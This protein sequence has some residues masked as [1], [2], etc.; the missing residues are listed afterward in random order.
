MNTNFELKLIKLSNKAYRKVL[1]IC[2][3]RITK[4]LVSV[5]EEL[6]KQMDFAEQLETAARQTL[7]AADLGRLAAVDKHDEESEALIELGAQ[8]RHTAGTRW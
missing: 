6:E 2:E 7:V 5:E 4:K 1:S 3:K 8:I